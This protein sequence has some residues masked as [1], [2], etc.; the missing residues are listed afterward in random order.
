[1]PYSC[2]TGRRPQFLDPAY[3][4][5]C[6]YH[7]RYPGIGCVHSILPPRL[8]EIEFIAVF[9]RHGKILLN[10]G[11]LNAEQDVLME[12]ILKCAVAAVQRVDYAGWLEEFLR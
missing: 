12:A 2:E 4:G 8:F 10:N 1:M 5:R 6:G 3:T 7:A 9:I 11:A